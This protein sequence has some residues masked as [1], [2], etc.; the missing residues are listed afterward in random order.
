MELL[1]EE[2]TRLSGLHKQLRRWIEGRDYN[3]LFSD[4]LPSAEFLE[5]KR[6]YIIASLQL[7]CHVQLISIAVRNTLKRKDWTAG[8][9]GRD[10]EYR[11][12]PDMIAEWSAWLPNLISYYL[13]TGHVTMLG[14]EFRHGAMKAENSMQTTRTGSLRKLL[15]TYSPQRLRHAIGFLHREWPKNMVAKFQAEVDNDPSGLLS[16]WVSR[17]EMGVRQDR[18]KDRQ[19]A[20]SVVTMPGAGNYTSRWKPWGGTRNKQT[21]SIQDGAWWE[22]DGNAE[23][24]DAEDE[25]EDKSYSDASKT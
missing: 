18:M 24:I 12:I 11:G 13:P 10:W 14:R 7:D 20:T 16:D 9:K 15:D 4:G 1:E 25:A 22:V 17:Y 23:D 3:H 21:P 19:V 8:D 2:R 5:L 6:R